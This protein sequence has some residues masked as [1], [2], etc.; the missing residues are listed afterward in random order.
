MVRKHFLRNGWVAEVKEQP[1][2][3]EAMKSTGK[4]LIAVGWI[5][6]IVVM[7]IDGVYW[8]KTGGWSKFLDISNN[9]KD[10]VVFT[11]IMLPGVGAHKLGEK[12]LET[13]AKDELRQKLGYSE[14]R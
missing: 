1:S 2:R 11:L 10:A 13:A 12:L 7:L 8:Y 4:S 14:R 5:Y 6:L 3:T 9:W